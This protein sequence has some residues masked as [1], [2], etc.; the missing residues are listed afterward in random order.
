[1]YINVHKLGLSD[2]S[3]LML[4]EKINVLTRAS[5]ILCQCQLKPELLPHQRERECKEVV[6]YSY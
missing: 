5:F 1:M 4:R 6:W 2:V 3:E